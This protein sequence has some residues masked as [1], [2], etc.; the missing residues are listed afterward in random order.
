LL[1]AELSLQLESVIAEQAKRNQAGGQGGILLS[2][3]LDNKSPLKLT[4]NSPKPPQSL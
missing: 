3:I 1:Y 4:A 2:R